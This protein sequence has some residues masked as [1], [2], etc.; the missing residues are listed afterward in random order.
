MSHVARVPIDF[1]KNESERDIRSGRRIKWLT[2][3]N[4]DDL[5]IGSG[6]AGKVK[7]RGRAMR[8]AKPVNRRA[9]SARRRLSERRVP[10]EQ[11]PDLV[12]KSHLTG[13]A[14]NGVRP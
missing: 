14:R 7:L 5:I 6:I 9:R 3:R 2:L 13:P 11:E 4:D 8:A 1:P 10:S 12:C